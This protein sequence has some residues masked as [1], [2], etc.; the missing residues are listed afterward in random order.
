[1]IST[2]KVYVYTMRSIL[3]IN[4]L[5]RASYTPVATYIIIII[6]MV[7]HTYYTS[8]HIHVANLNQLTRLSYTWSAQ[9]KLKKPK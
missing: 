3:T 2:K 8:M 6:I 5:M 9:S 1:M 4:K 7:G